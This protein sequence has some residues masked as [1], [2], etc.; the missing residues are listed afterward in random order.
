MSSIGYE[1]SFWLFD[2]ARKFTWS[3][4]V[5]VVYLIFWGAGCVGI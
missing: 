4:N 1:F 5:G 3:F 2:E